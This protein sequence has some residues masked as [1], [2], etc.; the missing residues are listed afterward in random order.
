MSS[1]ATDP[2]HQSQ[3][4]T[5]DYDRRGE[6]AAGGHAGAGNPFRFEGFYF[7]SG[8]KTYDTH[9]RHY[10]PDVGRFLSRDQ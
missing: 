9:A 6:V 2:Q 1:C 3:T 7:D 8:V 10:R 4:V 5:Y